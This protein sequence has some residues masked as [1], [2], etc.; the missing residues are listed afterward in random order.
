MRTFPWMQYCSFGSGLGYGAVT[1]RSAKWKM[2]MP[3][4][5][6]AV[7]KP[8]RSRLKETRLTGVPAR[9]TGCVAVVLA[10]IRCPAAAQNGGGHMMGGAGM[11]GS[12][13]GGFMWGMGLFWL[14]LLVLAVLGVIA[15]VKYLF[16]G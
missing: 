11:S 8:A 4:H 15:L 12:G 10:M 13:M 5:V 16:G 2:A 1:R 7:R 6:N 9:L 14:L 3:S